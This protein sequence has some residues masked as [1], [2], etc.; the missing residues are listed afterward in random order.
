M[1]IDIHFDVVCP[2]CFIGKRRL[3]R[4][5]EVRSDVRVELRWQPF[6][7]NPGMPRAG[8]G[9]RAYLAS[10]FG[11]PER[12]EQAYGMVREAAR[13]DGLTLD[14]DGI[15]RTPSTL[16]AHR[17][18]RFA[19]RDPGAMVDALFRAY[20]QEGRDI[21][22]RAV[23]ARIAGEQGYPATEAAAFLAG[24]AEVDA[25]RAAD[26]QARRLGVHA[27]PCFVFERRYAISGAQEPDAFLPLFDLEASAV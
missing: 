9:R 7:L 27:V 2:W 25:V 6:Q 16:D 17:L 22:D 10:K 8:M 15:E 21:G 13:R 20:F 1:L 4:A 14:L 18:V 12:A 11:S 19:A 5:L 24:T 23:L 3:A 26:A